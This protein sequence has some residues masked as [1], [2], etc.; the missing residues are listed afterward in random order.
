MS[1]ELIDIRSLEEKKVKGFGVTDKK[2]YFFFLSSFFFSPL[3]PHFPQD[4][5]DL[6]WGRPTI[7]K[8]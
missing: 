6:L 7:I 3:G 1:N 8:L 2:H 5:L 4:M